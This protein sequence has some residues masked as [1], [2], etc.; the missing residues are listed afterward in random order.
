MHLANYGSYYLAMYNRHL[1]SCINLG[2]NT[3]IG[4]P[5]LHHV[6]NGH[7]EVDPAPFAPVIANCYLPAVL[8]IEHKAWSRTV[9]TVA[10]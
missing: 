8:S 1:Y 4:Q 3:C 5:F 9:A 7:I 6:S 2:I 10:N